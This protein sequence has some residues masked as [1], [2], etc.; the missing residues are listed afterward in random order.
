MKIAYKGDIVTKESVLSDSFVVV[1]NGIISYVGKDMPKDC[2]IV[3]YSGKYILPGFIDIHCHASA[4]NMAT[5]D[6]KEVAA[7]HKSHGTTSMLLTYYRDIPHEKLLKCL[8]EVKGLVGKSN[9]IGAHLEG[10]ILNANFGTGYGNPQEFPDKAK[11]GKYVA[12]GVVKQ[13]T[14]SPEV[15]GVP[16][17][18]K[19]IA[20][21]GIVPSIGHSEA[22]YSQVLTAYNAG[23]RLATHIFDATGTTKDESTMAGTEDISFDEACML[24]DDMYYEVICDS[25]WVHVKKEKLALLI[26]TVGIDRVIAITDS[27]MSDGNEDS[28][29]NVFYMSDGHAS[30][31]G[32]KLTMDRVAE[33]LHGAGYSPVDIAKMTAY[34]AAKLLRLS[35]RGEI[36]AGKR[37]DLL[38][39]SSDMQLIK[40][41]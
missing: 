33:N 17:M 40:V 36:A 28:D 10:P 27:F 35:D 2:D 18:I 39:V 4:L 30:L 5:D 12:S 13:W 3:D 31:S 14:S 15:D 16:E 20:A 9:V 29:I 11:Y 23:A 24:M 22:S 19:D 25:N 8:E 41:L 26:K 34:N 7:Y 1:E 38:L 32:S 6:P 21:A 37:A